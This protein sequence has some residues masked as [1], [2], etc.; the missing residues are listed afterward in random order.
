MCSTSLPEAV[1]GHSGALLGGRIYISGGETVR[2]HQNT[3][4]SYDPVSEIWREEPPLL[5][6][7]SNHSM[8][9][10]EGRLVVIGGDV[11]GSLVKTIEIFDPSN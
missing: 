2:G 5:R 8:V 1:C 3:V 7:R 10:C 4:R 9:E 6:K 11:G